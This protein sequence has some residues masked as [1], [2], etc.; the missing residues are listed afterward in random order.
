[1]DM[2]QVFAHIAGDYKYVRF[3]DGHISWSWCGNCVRHKDLVDDRP[4]VKPISAGK[5]RVIDKRWVCVGKG[6]TSAG[7]HSL[8]DDDEKIQEWIGSEYV[9]DIDVMYAW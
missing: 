8:D 9:E 7:L 6:G 5:I 2:S 1:M 3:E 4:N